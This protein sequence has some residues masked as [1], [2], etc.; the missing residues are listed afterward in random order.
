MRMCRFTTLVAEP[1]GEVCGGTGSRSANVGGQAKTYL[2]PCPRSSPGAPT[3]PVCVM[4]AALRSRISAK[5]KRTPMTICR[6]GVSEMGRRVSRSLV[7][8]GAGRVAYK[9]GVFYLLLRVDKRP[10]ER[11]GVPRP[12][13]PGIG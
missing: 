6:S 12:R 5:Y 1:V 10:V 13:G 9:T 7:Q 4:R 2:Y 3:C 8:E 11:R